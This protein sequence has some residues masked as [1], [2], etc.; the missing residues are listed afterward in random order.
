MTVEENIQL[1]KRVPLFQCLEGEELKALA[2]VSKVETFNKGSVVISEGEEDRFD[3][4]LIVEGQVKI[5]KYKR[6]VG[7]QR[8]DDGK[9]ITLGFKTAGDCFG[10]MSLLDRQ[11]RSAEVSTT[12]RTKLLVVSQNSFDTIVMKNRKAVGRL[13]RQI[14]LHLR[15]ADRKISDYTLMDSYGKVARL[16]LEADEKSTSHTFE[17]NVTQIS[18]RV[19]VSTKYVSQ[20]LLELEKVLCIE[21]YGNQKLRVLDKNFPATKRDLEDRLRRMK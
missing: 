17:G 5:I 8:S 7:G 3:F 2:G 16:I 11:K 9:Y 1:L 21:R 20:W 18:E 10:E 4:F 15:E 13:I 12:R 19:G 14:L 6:T